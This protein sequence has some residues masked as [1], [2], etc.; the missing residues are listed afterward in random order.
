[1]KLL[2]IAV[3]N[4]RRNRRRTILNVIALAV[5]LGI[6]LIAFGWINGYQV[7]I[8]GTLQDI[9]TGHVQILNREY[10]DEAVRLPLDLNVPN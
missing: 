8:Y 5:G 4:I 7:Y 1:M 6:A 9:E 2:R 10:L 3:R